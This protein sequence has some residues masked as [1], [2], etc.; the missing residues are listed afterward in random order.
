MFFQIMSGIF[1]TAF[2]CYKKKEDFDGKFDCS[3]FVQFC[4]NQ[5]GINNVPHSSSEI[6]N[7][8]SPGDGSIGDIAC[9]NGHVGICD[10]KGNVIHSYHDGH[11]IVAHTIKQVSDKKWNGPLKGY[12]RF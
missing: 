6:W 4:Y 9:W 2:K 11:L 7:K 1:E 10:G 12:R 5:N 8:G 3:G